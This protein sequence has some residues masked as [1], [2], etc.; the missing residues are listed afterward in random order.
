MPKSPTNVPGLLTVAHVPVEPFWPGG[1]LVT[2]EVWRRWFDNLYNR[3]GGA[4]SVIVL[5]G[6]L[7]A[8]P[9]VEISVS[10]SMVTISNTGVRSVNV[11]GGTT[12]L[13]FVGG[14]VT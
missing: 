9:G 11:D 12:G 10:G 13:T 7:V 14:P 8:G 6:N 2:S 1:P 4:T 3:V 5:T